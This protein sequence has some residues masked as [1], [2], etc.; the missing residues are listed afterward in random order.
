[1]KGVMLSRRKILIVTLFIVIGLLFLG[2]V[3]L[4]I[5]GFMAKRDVEVQLEAKWADLDRLY[6]RNPFPSDLNLKV[7]Q[8]NLDVI[9]DEMRGLLTAMGQG[10]I[11][12]VNQS[13]PKFMAQFWETRT[14]LKAQARSTGVALTGGDDFDF[15]FSRHMAGNLPAP[16]DV[17]RLTQQLRIVQALCGVLYNARITEL[18]GVGREEFE[19]DAAGGPT[20]RAA[21]A[22][23]RRNQGAQA[24]LNMTRVNAGLIPEGRL[25]GK[26]RFVL[27]FSARESALLNVL[28]GL[29]RSPVF[30]VVTRVEV[31]GDDKLFQKQADPNARR[32]KRAGD[33]VVKG[34]SI[35]KEGLSNVPR[36]QR[37][38]CGQNVA[39]LVVRLDL[40]V[41]QFVKLQS[42]G[43]GVKAGGDK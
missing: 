22:A 14:E 23:G 9:N 6:H 40:D 2:A 36:D 5:R 20:S 19:V 24:S 4:V 16:Q 33:A 13:P 18:K 26:W 32:D 42:A 38:V 10:Q 35:S 3:G 43:D 17:P 25:F 34:P 39:P 1:M 15:G 27:V 21:P 7:E 30:A 11:E 31:I 28:N 12:S 29:A 8:K 37:V 41:L